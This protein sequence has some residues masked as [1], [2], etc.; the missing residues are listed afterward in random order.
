MKTEIKLCLPRY[1]LIYSIFFIIILSLVRGINSTYEIGIAM[2]TPT[3]FL[4]I[5][6]CSDTYLSEHL[7]KRGDIFGLYSIKNRTRII[8]NRILIQ[9]VY[10]TVISVCGYVLFFVKCTLPEQAATE[11]LLFV[12]F[13]AA[14]AMT[15]FFWGM[16]SMTISNF[17]R[18]MWVGISIP[19]V[20]W[21]VFNS[22]SSSKFLGKWNVFSYTF[23]GNEHLYDWNW[24]Y[25]KIIPMLLVMVMFL[26]IPIILKKR[27]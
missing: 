11:C 21:L 26:T 2:E 9:L 24:I 16:L 12:Q 10:L 23:R 27:G 17:A 15:I 25:G 1:K 4:T 13:L 18:N 22:V 5:V 8:K 7:N 14:I 20:L 19:F 6:F 3:A